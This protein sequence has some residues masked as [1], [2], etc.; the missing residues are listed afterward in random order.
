[1]KPYKTIAIVEDTTSSRLFLSRLLKEFGETVEDYECA[2]SFLASGFE[3]ELLVTDYHLPN[4]DGL[5]MLKNLKYEPKKILFLTCDSVTNSVREEVES[6]GS[7]FI[8]KPLTIKDLKNNVHALP[9][10]M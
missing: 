2:E 3:A 9:R 5:T 7:T 4:M 10:N 8:L 6:L 1:M